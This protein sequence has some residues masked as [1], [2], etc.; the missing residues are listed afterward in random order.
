MGNGT[1]KVGKILNRTD[2]GGCA[3]TKNIQIFVICWGRPSVDKILMK[4]CE[5]STTANKFDIF[6]AYTPY[7]HII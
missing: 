2:G 4:A 6:C 3:Y 5:E 7:Y 1:Q